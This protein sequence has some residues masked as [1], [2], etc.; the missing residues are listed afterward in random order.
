MGRPEDTVVVTTLPTEALTTAQRSSVIEVCVLAHENDEFKNLFTYIPTG[1]RHFLAYRGHELV[2]HAMVTTRWVQPE[3][4]RAFKTAYVDAVSTLPMYQ[5]RGFG[6][7][8]MGRLAAEIGDYEVGCLQT[9]RP[10]FYERLG[11]ALWRGT[12]AGRSE[13]GLVPT[14]NQRG[15]MV[16]RLPWTPPLDLETQLTI[17][18]QPDRIWE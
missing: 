18:C 4:Q 12:L 9:D 1:A 15:V 14:P 7:A 10:A 13:D 5:G 8:T 16:L 11:W 3:G 2:S 6:T 17:E